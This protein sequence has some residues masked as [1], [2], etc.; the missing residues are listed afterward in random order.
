MIQKTILICIV[1]LLTDECQDQ[2]LN[3]HVN[4]SPPKAFDVVTSNSVGA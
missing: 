1:D 2:M 4:T 3:L